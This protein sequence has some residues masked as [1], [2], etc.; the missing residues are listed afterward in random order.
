MCL[1]LGPCSS[2]SKSS[3]K[4]PQFFHSF[5]SQ[6]CWRLETFNRKP[7]SRR[8]DCVSL[9][10]F[11]LATL[12]LSIRAQST[13]PTSSS[14]QNL[15]FSSTSWTQ[16]IL[17]NRNSPASLC[18]SLCVCVCVS[19]SLCLQSVCKERR[20]PVKTFSLSI[21]RKAHEQACQKKL[22]NSSWCPALVPLIAGSSTTGVACMHA[23]PSTQKA[24][25]LRTG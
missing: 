2:T 17:L 4:L 10:F 20:F 22:S 16:S 7:A 18:V 8:L 1:L 6:L 12:M 13:L 11:T 19:L 21:T 5:R 15:H 9:K 3:S 23:S 25:K 24:Y 14:F